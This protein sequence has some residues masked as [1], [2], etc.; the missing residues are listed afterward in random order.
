MRTMALEAT[1]ARDANPGA[2]S[3]TRTGRGRAA[4][5]DAARFFLFITN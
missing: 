3:K 2:G 4:S 5:P 1:L